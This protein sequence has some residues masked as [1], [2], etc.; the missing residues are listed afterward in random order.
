MQRRTVRPPVSKRQ[1]E[2]VGGPPFCQAEKEGEEGLV[3][4]LTELFEEVFSSISS[5]FSFLLDVSDG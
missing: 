3:G 4:G 1:G 5:S 2:E